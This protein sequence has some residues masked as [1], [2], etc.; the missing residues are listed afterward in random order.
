MN[1][2]INFWK[3][4]DLSEIINA[5]FVFI[6]AHFKNLAKVILMTAGPFLLIT[7]I[8]S[9]WF[10]A[11]LVMPTMDERIENPLVAFEM[12]KGIR[13]YLNLIAAM[14]GSFVMYAAMYSYVMLARDGIYPTVDNVWERIRE[15]AG[16]YITTFLFVMSLYLASLA[17]FA[18]SCFG[19]LIWFVGGIYLVTILQVYLPTRLH[20]RAGAVEAVGR[21][22]QLNKGQFGNSFL[23]LIVLIVIVIALA[24]VF[25]LPAMVISFTYSLNSLT[26]SVTQAP[27]WVLTLTSVFQIFASLTSIVPVTATLIHYCNLVER[28]ESP[29]LASRVEDWAGS[30]DT[31]SDGPQ[32]YRSTGSEP[33][34][35]HPGDPRLSNRDTSDT[36]QDSEGNF[37][38]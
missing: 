14:I 15:D 24:A 38:S 28:F 31:P 34:G 12:F 3:I 22:Y 29:G 18:L 8:L 7:A 25:M 23:L 17:L 1:Q 35:H 36:D 4:R 5:T 33:T 2:E 21:C 10:Q 26:G 32:N 16:L 27:I 20:E 37:S 11:N 19:V 9:V 13:F 30:K 6:K